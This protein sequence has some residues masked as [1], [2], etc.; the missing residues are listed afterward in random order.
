MKYPKSIL[1][2]LIIF[3]LTI[4]FPLQASAASPFSYEVKIDV[5][6]G[7]QLFYNYGNNGSFFLSSDWEEYNPDCQVINGETHS[8]TKLL[9]RGLIAKPDTGYYFEGFYDSRGKKKSIKETKIDILRVSVKG[10]YFYNYFPS[11]ENKSYQRLTKTA[12]QNQ[13]KMFLKGLYGTTRYKVMDTVTLYTLPKGDGVYL[14]KFQEKQLPSLSLPEEIIKTYG[15][16]TFPLFDS[17]PE[18]LD[19]SFRASGSKVVTIN[20]QTGSITIKGPGSTTVTCKVRESQRTLP[21]EFETVVT[22][23]PAPVKKLSAKR[24]KKLLSVKWSSSIKNSGYEI[25]VSNNENF[26]N[27]IGKKTVSGGKT[28]TTTLKLK[29]EVC[30]NYVRIRP[31]KVSRGNKIYSRYTVAEIQS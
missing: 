8:F 18:D 22:V 21:A 1:L 2:S 9:D 3:L 20:K 31:Y 5:Q 30:N 28:N 14:A 13:V 26:K 25:Q 12:Y 16:E 24:T 27:I 7:G 10:F 23:K 19:C 15:N 17:I 11:R 6:P 29:S 4:I